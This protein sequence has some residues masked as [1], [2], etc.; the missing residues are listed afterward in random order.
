MDS[1]SIET[2]EKAN[3]VFILCNALELFDP[4]SWCSPAHVVIVILSPLSGAAALLSL[5]PLLPGPRLLLVIA[6]GLRISLLI[7]A[8]LKI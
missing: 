3:L 5:S 6:V 1:F 8:L 4:A 7:L 2:E